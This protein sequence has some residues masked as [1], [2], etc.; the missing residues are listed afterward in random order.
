MNAIAAKYNR[1][2]ATG[3]W[4]SLCDDSVRFAHPELCR[5]LGRWRK[6]A[7]AGAIPKYTDMTPRLLKPFLGDVVL[8]EHLA[9]TGDRRWRVRLMGQSFAQIMG[10]LSG[11]FLDSAVPPEFLPRWNTA[12]DCT[13]AYRAPLRFLGRMT[14]N[15]M[16]FLNGEYFSAPLLDGNGS[17]TLVLAAGRFTGG[18]SWEDVEAEARKTLA[19]E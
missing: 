14:T 2:A 8:Y 12:L 17:A 4:Q 5:L 11:L 3:G 19:L 15:G 18:R 1:I 13:L 6:Q 16:G 10:D 7:K 9:E